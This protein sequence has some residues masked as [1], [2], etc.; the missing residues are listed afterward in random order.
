MSLVPNQ[1]DCKYCVFEI[2]IEGV[3]EWAKYR[4]VIVT[5]DGRTLY[6]SDPYAFFSDN[7]PETC[8]KV[9]DID[10]YYWHDKEY[11]ENRKNK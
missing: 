9:Y 10:G 11:L 8:S 3:G 2:Y 6:K 1:V 5:P 7:R 4:Y